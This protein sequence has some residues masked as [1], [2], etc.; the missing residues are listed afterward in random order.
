[1][2]RTSWFDDIFARRWLDVIARYWPEMKAAM[3]PAD[4]A[5]TAQTQSDERQIVEQARVLAPVV[6]MI[7]KVQSGKT[8]LVRT[9]TGATAAEI[10]NGYMPCTRHAAVFDFPAEAPVIRFLDTRGLGEAGYDADED[11]A[12]HEAQA[13][14]LIAVM[15]ALDP[16]Q[17]IVL[18]VVRKARE[19]HPGW[20]VIVAQTT[21]HDSYRAGQRH[22]QPYPYA[23]LPAELAL[24][25]QIPPDLARAL[26]HQRGLFADLPGDGPLFFVPLDFTLPGDGY[27]PADYGLEAFLGALE[28]AA[29]AGLIAA[30]HESRPPRHDARAATAHPH[31]V[32]YA[33]AAAA[34]D[35]V[36]A[37]GAVA[38]PAVQA[39]MLHS[40]GRIY[41]VGWD[42]RTLGEFGAC[43][44]AGTATRLL[45]GFGIRQIAKLVP[46]YGQTAGA[47]AAAAAS[48][49]TTFAIGKAACHFLSRRR[50]GKAD[51]AG[52][53]DAY[54]TALAEAF[55]MFKRRDPYR[56]GTS[57]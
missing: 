32:G 19:R 22:A 55:E 21:L 35:A 12:F 31:I 51:P 16:Q 28:A 29:P 50:E 9:L 57:L 49:A 42:R 56:T 24:N 3:L 23:A 13:H 4:P 25:P 8:S 5:G 18:D 34:A 38:V 53:S 44:G 27:E 11:I 17:G 40:L 45:A 6:W 43:L 1:M 54:K 52:V 46:V 14:L 20:P 48:F 7:G 30:L 2:T 37:A 26:A 15:K 41:G 33:T 39:K 47:A 10:G 36:P